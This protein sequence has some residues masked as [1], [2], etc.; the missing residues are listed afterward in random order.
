MSPPSLAF[1]IFAISLGVRVFPFGSGPPIDVDDVARKSS[2]FCSASASLDEALA[3]RK[4][5]TRTTPARTTQIMSVL[6]FALHAPKK[7]SVS[8][9]KI[10]FELKEKKKRHVAHKKRRSRGLGYSR[11]TVAFRQADSTKREDKIDK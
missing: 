5:A 10:F 1:I 6:L 3:V 9:E 7:V 11:V 2:F 8:F 4:A